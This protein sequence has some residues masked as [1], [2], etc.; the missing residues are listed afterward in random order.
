MSYSDERELLTRELQ[1]RSR[2]PDTHPLGL[3]A[4]KDRARGIQRR[5]RT[6]GAATAAVVMA[7][8][9]PVGINIAGTSQSTAPMPANP[10]PSVAESVEPNP[11]PSVVESVDTRPPTETPTP[12]PTPNR[13]DRPIPADGTAAPRGDAPSIAYLSGSTLHLSEGSTRDLGRAYDSITPYQGG[14]VGFTY[15]DGII[16]F[17]DADGG[18]RDEVSGTGPVIAPDGVG[19]AYTATGRDST[20]VVLTST[21]GSRTPL[22]ASVGPGAVQLV[23][24][25]ADEQVAYT[26]TGKDGT[27]GVFVTDFEGAPV[28]LKGLLNSKGAHAPAGVVSGMTSYDESEP[29]SC[30]AV[31]D[32]A[33]QQQA[34]ETCDF[35]LTRFSPDG[36]FVLGVDEYQDGIGGSQVAILDAVDGTV[37][38]DYTT[39][40]LGFTREP[41][42]ELDSTALLST[43]QD[44]SWYLLRLGPDG[45]L[46]QALDPMSGDEMEQPW[47]FALRP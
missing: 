19:L 33:T 45:A 32:V 8:A 14:Y 18:V 31:L 27:T 35:T 26:V 6:V 39:R 25:T 44:G 10:S 13:R 47:S 36:R 24:F 5:R 34:W 4:V 23:G 1:D 12:T 9:V 21:D 37:L 15:R 7:V 17:L 16:R 11:S 38:A 42:W 46:E 20:D 30:W 29:G 43:F 41:V 22:M 3:D 40:D 2:D 28:R